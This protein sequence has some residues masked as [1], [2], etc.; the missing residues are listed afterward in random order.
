MVCANP[1]CGVEFEVER[2]R[3]YAQKYCSKKCRWTAQN[4]RRP[5]QRIP[6]ASEMSIYNSVTELQIEKLGSGDTK[7][8]PRRRKRTSQKRRL[9]CGR[10][11]AFS[12]GRGNG[13]QGR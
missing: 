6:S 2:R 4:I 3:G 11:T 1:K 10:K 12:A 5:L 9:R 13:A 7:I 8:A